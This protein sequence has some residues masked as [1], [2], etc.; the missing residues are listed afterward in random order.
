[1]KVSRLSHEQ[2]G[3]HYRSLNVYEHVYKC[4]LSFTKRVTSQQDGRKTT[5]ISRNTNFESPLQSQ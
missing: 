1:V 5:E 3:V 4:S 2:Y